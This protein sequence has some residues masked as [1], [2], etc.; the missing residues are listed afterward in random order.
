MTCIRIPAVLLVMSTFLAADGLPVAE[1]KRSEPLD[2]A[3]DVFPFLNKNCLPC[4]NSTKAKGGLNMETPQ[5]MHKG[6]DN[7]P[8]ILPGKGEGS[9]LFIAASHRDE[10][11]DMHMPPPK[12]KA[13]ARHLTPEELGLLKDWID[14]G[15]TGL[16]PSQI[17]R[18]LAWRPVAANIHPILTVTLDRL[19]RY[20][21]C[22]RGNDVHIYNLQTGTREALLSKAHRD[23]V[24]AV[25]FGR[26]HVLA[27]AG[28]REVRFWEAA[29]GSSDLDI[30]MPE[31]VTAGTASPDGTWILLGDA[32]G[33]VARWQIDGRAKLHRKHIHQGRI[34]AMQLLADNTR[35]MTASEDQ[36]ARILERD[37][38][39]EI[40]KLEPGFPISDALL[41]NAD[42]HL[43]LSGPFNE[44]K[45]YEL[46]ST[47]TPI[48]LTGH[49]DTV[50]H[51]ARHPGD[52]KQFFA[53]DASGQ[54]RHWT[55]EGSKQ[56]RT[57]NVGAPLI[58][59]AVSPD[60]ALLCSTHADRPARLWRTDNGQLVKDLKG[61][62]SLAWDQELREREHKVAQ[63]RKLHFETR[64]KESEKRLQEDTKKH[65]EAE[66]ALPK[67]TKAKEDKEKVEAEKKRVK[68][69]ADALVKQRE[70]EELK[71]IEEQKRVVKTAGDTVD[72]LQ[73]DVVTILPKAEEEKKAKDL[74]A[75]QK[76]HAMD[77]ANEA[78]KQ[79]EIEQ[80]RLLEE[81]RK[82]TQST[83]GA[84][85]KARQEAEGLLPKARE[86][87][88]ANDTLVQQKE[89]ELHAANERATRKEVEQAADLEEVRQQAQQ[90]KDALAASQKESDKI[91][92][93]AEAAKKA[94]DLVVQQKQRE[95]D[96][97]NEQLK[98]REAEQARKLEEARKRVQGAKE[99]YETVK[100]EADAVRPAAQ[101]AKVKKDK[102]IQAKQKERDAANHLVRQLE[103]GD[104][105]ELAEA[106][107]NAKKPTDEFEKANKEA[108]EARAS[109]KSAQFS[110]EAAKRILH[111]SGE[112][113]AL[114]KASLEEGDRILTEANSTLEQARKA[115][116]EFKPKPGGATFLNAEH[117]VVS[118]QGKAL[119][120]WSK[121]GTGL[122]VQ[123]LDATG[124]CFIRAIDARRVLVGFNDKKVRVQEVI[125]NWKAGR[126]I[127]NFADRVTALD[128]SPDGQWLATGSGVPSRMGRLA[129]WKVADGVKILE[130][131]KAH[132]DT[133]LGLAF[134]PNG[135]FI[136]TASPDRMVKIW[137]VPEGNLI[138]TL[139]GH[140]DYVLGVAWRA[141]G[142][143]LA[144]SGADKVVKRWQFEDGKQVQTL[145]EYS[146]E[147]TAVSYLGIENSL[148]SSSGDN[149]VRVDNNRLGNVE[150]FMH[151]ATT[152]LNGKF[153]AAGGEDGV[154]KVWTADRKIL[155]EFKP[156][157]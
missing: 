122:D 88:K 139:E 67:V 92:P 30:T 43:V 55:I 21:A 127:T 152:S 120:G 153:I 146:R 125:P 149:S 62:I 111:R 35:L 99:A 65:K 143:E 106:K 100:K 37:T 1:V 96:A 103:K 112:K 133:I 110:L 90:A 126:T 34:S 78:M 83:K 41:I 18:P 22:G 76:K 20:A 14:Q 108:D 77:A 42:K 57:I 109:L 151:T 147:V 107:K 64:Q 56:L 4:H 89:Q 144:S 85:E 50:T 33:H 54:V 102:R 82:F 5:L 6:S 71:Q 61:N 12:N 121:A 145:K 86:D 31:Q 81:A 26:D 39:D 134:S 36:T 9:F 3:K 116:S 95:R 45:V 8:V 74:V 28:Y 97:A 49:G 79:T 104:G 24:Q 29:R 75:Q 15:A 27:T 115:Q 11:P 105:K 25:A 136:A 113:L 141:D 68:E 70:A 63:K 117:V 60:G 114:S 13:N 48:T 52:S 137:S 69:T 123:P 94:Q 73:K 53:A 131:A 93:R 124:I 59:L 38:L 155:H 16:A 23:L 148:V 138:R 154:L 17:N 32:S 101:A 132:A 156:G 87:K 91:L 80:M 47:N 129:I 7:G 142:L 135:K 150:G 84:W 66:E 44:I 128:F 2:Y 157:E 118:D 46:M 58:D 51:L 72:Q 140:T 98:Q 130:I 40:W 10:D 119:M 19:G